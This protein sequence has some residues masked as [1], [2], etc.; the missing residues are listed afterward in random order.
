MPGN[1]P[2]R[3]SDVASCAMA[4]SIVA[5]PP[6]ADAG[7]PGSGD[8][9]W[10]RLEDQIGW[11]DAKSGLNQRRFKLCKYAEIL[12]AAAIPVGAALDGPGWVAAVLGGLILMLEG[13]QHLNQYQQNWIT[14]RSTCE[15]LKH[16][17]FL[18]LARAGP[19]SGDTNAPAVLAERIEGLISQEHAK[20]TSSR[21]EQTEPK[22]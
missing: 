19:Y 14:Y 18:F 5:E 13:I 21:A 3:R 11:Y 4:R 15:A 2:R 22:A 9:T 12:A 8:P 10:E 6:G 7:S 17:K 16:E 20:W 1:V